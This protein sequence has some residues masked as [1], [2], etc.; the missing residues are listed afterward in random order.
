MTT[1]PMLQESL[2]EASANI[3]IENDQKLHTEK[4]N[5]VNRVN[6]V[7]SIRNG[8]IIQP[9]QLQPGR[10]LVDSSSQEASPVP[11]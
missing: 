11:F 5:H 2:D 4:A 7:R 9:A 1:H 10:S 8:Q 3:Q 6:G